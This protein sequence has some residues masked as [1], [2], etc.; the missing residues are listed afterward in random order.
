MYRKRWREP[1][2][3]KKETHIN[4]EEGKE[5]ARRRRDRT[6]ATG[7]R[8]EREEETEVMPPEEEE[9]EKKTQPRKEVRIRRSCRPERF[10]Q[11]EE[12]EPEP[13]PERRPQCDARTGHILPLTVTLNQDQ[14]ISFT[15]MKVKANHPSNHKVSPPFDGETETDKDVPETKGCRGDMKQLGE[16]GKGKLEGTR[17]RGDEWTRGR[18]DEGTRGR[19]DEGT[20]G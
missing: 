14:P 10:I 1:R 3:R 12:P 11:N 8:G 4:A 5:G 6:E 2:E 19:G 13:A 17:G 16:E 9:K 15:Y 18:G 20:R 7:G